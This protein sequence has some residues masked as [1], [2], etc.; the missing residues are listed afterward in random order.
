[1]IDFKAW[2]ELVESIEINNSDAIF[3]EAY[4]IKFGQYKNLNFEEI[5]SKKKD[6]LDWMRK[7]IRDPDKQTDFPV[8]DDVSNKFLTQQEIADA[9]RNF[10]NQKE[11]DS[12]TRKAPPKQAAASSP[13]SEKKEAPTSSRTDQGLSSRVASRNAPSVDDT[14]FLAVSKG[15]DEFENDDAIVLQEGPTAGQYTIYKR[16]GT[17]KSVSE[18]RLVGKISILTRSNGSKISHKNPAILYEVFDSVDLNSFRKE[19]FEISSEK[20]NVE[21]TSAKGSIQTRS[22]KGGTEKTSSLEPKDKEP[23]MTSSSLS[24]SNK[25]SSDTEDSPV[26]QSTSSSGSKNRPTPQQVRLTSDKMT[27]YNKRIEDSFRNNNDGIMIDALAGTGKTT[28]LKHLS[29]FIKPNEK[30]LYLV[31]NKKNAEE[32]KKS[33]PKGVDVMTTHVFLGNILKKALPE[34]GGN[35][36]LA[37]TVDK[38]YRKLNVLVDEVIKEKTWPSTTKNTERNYYSNKFQ[39]MVSQDNYAAKIAVKK[40]CELAKAYAIKPTSSSLLDDLENIIEEHKLLNAKNPKK[41]IDLYVYEPEIL[42]M[43]KKILELS[44]PKALETNNRNYSLRDHD[45][46]L[47]FTAIHADEITNWNPEGYDVVLM[48]EVQD[49]NECQLIM[50]KKLKEAGCRVIGVGDPNQ[51]MY[52]FRGADS[53]AFD[54]L[55]EIIGGREVFPLPMNFRSGGN[56]INYV[57]NNTH[58]SNLEAA[59]HLQNQGEVY[60]MEGGTKAAVNYDQFVDQLSNEFRSDRLAKEGTAFISRTNSSLAKTALELMRRNIDF[61]ILG[62]DLSKEIVDFVKESLGYSS[63]Q[64]VDISDVISQVGSHYQDLEEKWEGQ[65]KKKEELKDAKNIT[66]V[67]VNLVDY[68]EDNDYKTPETNLPINNAGDLIKYIQKKFSGEDPDDLEGAQKIKQKDPRKTITLTTAHK[69][70][71]LEWDRVFILDPNQFDPNSPKNVTQE[72]KQQEKNAKY[73]AFTRA[74]KSLYVAPDES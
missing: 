29:S 9:I 18:N 35:T 72:Q 5:Y 36:N 14:I 61:Q 58:V 1:M 28:M 24:P 57:K 33:F 45:D 19:P 21:K 43:T 62:Q 52:L 27:E 48:D 26:Q 74:K 34:Y 7:Q 47:W 65:V 55:K 44:M 42:E 12:R 70:K 38:K 51:A 22:E 71:G 64:N 73:V 69:S 13:S 25:I 46:T 40:L 59:P 60:A 11:I 2:F 39:V 41:Q 16:D 37:S 4:I 66:E 8:Y 54:K 10:K 30:W 3:C 53:K 68:L 67:I 31:F 56:I 15:F 20:G 32:G 50:A 63:P 17:N 49:F 6:Y 23:R